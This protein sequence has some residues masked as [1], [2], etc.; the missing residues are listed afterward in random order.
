MKP[1]RLFF[2]LIA[3]AII[4]VPAWAQQCKSNKVPN[5]PNSR[6]TTLGNGSEVQDNVSK[7]IWQRCS[8]GQLWN[9]KT[10]LGAA[11]GYKWDVVY[12]AGSPKLTKTQVTTPEAVPQP[13]ATSN[14]NAP[15]ESDA[16]NG[17]MAEPDDA[18]P[19]AVADAP[20][21]A[22]RELGW[23]LPTLKEL[24]TLVELACTSPSIN[25]V[26]FPST[27]TNFY[28]SSS[29]FSDDDNFAWGVDFNDGRASYDAKKS[30]SRVRLVRFSP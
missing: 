30:S 23:R 5:A 10:C 4:T 6:Y 26:M 25:T 27:G 19:P 3:I 21:P 22:S 13:T 14:T 7:L 24:F 20:K 17:D 29:T 11:I 1:A 9:G 2:A 15:E 28:W 16:D 18:S 8:M 12:G